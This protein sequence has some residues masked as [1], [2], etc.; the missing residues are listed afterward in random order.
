MSFFSRLFG[1]GK[2]EKQKELDPPPKQEELIEED[3]NYVEENEKRLQAGG[4]SPEYFYRIFKENFP[5]YQIERTVS[6]R[7][8]DASCHEKCH[9]IDF[10]F[11]QNGAPVLAVVLTTQN[12]YR[13]MPFRGTEAVCDANDVSYMRFFIEMRNERNYVRERVAEELEE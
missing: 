9:P 1:K 3:I 12:Q 2:Q 10:L 4:I 6:A 13:S 8:L 11:S 5:Q 7:R